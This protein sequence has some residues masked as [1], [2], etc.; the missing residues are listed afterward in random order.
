LTQ[1]VVASPARA[2]AATS[3]AVLS[4]AALAVA[5]VA[6]GV[7]LEVPWLPVDELAAVTGARDLGAG[8]ARAGALFPLLFWLPAQALST[9]T[10]LALTKIVAGVAA[11]GTLLPA[12]LLARRVAEPRAA[13]AAAVVGVFGPAA[14]YGAAALPDTLALLAATAALA[15]A[16]RDRPRAAVALA[17]VA[18]LARPWFLPLPVAVWYAVATRAER[19]RLFTWPGAAAFVLVAGAAYG[20]YALSG[21]GSVSAAVRA[22][23]GSLALASLAAGVVPWVLAWAVRGAD[24][25]RRLL[26]PITIAAAAGAAFAG[27]GQ[28][29]AVDERAAL[30]LVPLLLALAAAAL[31]REL[32]LR[33]A[34]RAAAALVLFALVLPWPLH[35][36]DPGALA[37]ALVRHLPADALLVAVVAVLALAPAVDPRRARPALA[38]GVALVVAATLAGWVDAAD[39]SRDLERFAPSPRT[40]VDDAV[41]TGAA[42]TWLL[43]PREGDPR[44]IAEARLW[45]RSLRRVRRVDLEQADPQTGVLPVGPLGLTLTSALATAVGGD[46]VARTP[47]GS[48]LRMAGPPRAAE[49]VVGRYS[50]GWSGGET[51]YR[52]FLGPPHESRLVVTA[53]REL[54]SGPDRP[55]RVIVDVTDARGN[56]FSERFTRIHARKKVRLRLPVPPPPFQAIVRVTPTFSPAKLGGSDP[57]KLGAV[58]SFAY[59]G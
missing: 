39:A 40:A 45:N 7:A 29:P 11:V 16:A 41:G 37:G 44:G 19:R 18:A 52:R 23:A 28:E 26:G 47:Y 46:V 14:L 24:D 58:V 33:R 59:K 54:W 1:T 22:G 12:Y 30:V 15:A 43:L 42:V 49:V 50:D 2:S 32:D 36:A 31:E 55:A 27:A 57:R 51:T 20:A 4:V 6:A 17:A 8:G 10:F 38:A 3:P 56:P 48:V 25:V 21:A 35:A 34:R 5:L 53:S 13:A 9:G